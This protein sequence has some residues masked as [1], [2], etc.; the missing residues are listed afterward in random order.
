MLYLSAGASPEEAGA[1][2]CTV[3]WRIN[4]ARGVC[5]TA[6]AY[7]R[8]SVIVSASSS[9]S[10]RPETAVLHNE[11]GASAVS[12]DQLEP[13]REKVRRAR[14]EA[15]APERQLPKRDRSSR[16]LT[17]ARCNGWWRF[18]SARQLQAH[19]TAS[20]RAFRIVPQRH[21]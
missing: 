11:P 20:Y 8:S 10:C 1:V 3:I 5:L 21:H 15:G 16:R 18:P 17:L 6:I 12:D 9:I 14:S 13:N 7:V 19:A 4:V 2:R